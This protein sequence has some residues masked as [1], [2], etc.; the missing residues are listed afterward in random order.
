M[1]S[2]FVDPSMRVYVCDCVSV[3][4]SAVVCL[5]LFAY[6]CLHKYLCAA[7]VCAKI[8]ELTIGVFRSVV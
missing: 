2:A 1:F 6:L 7:C 5:C 8:T 4:V 3:G